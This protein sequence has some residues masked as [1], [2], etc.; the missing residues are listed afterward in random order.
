MSGHILFILVEGD[1]ED[2]VVKNFLKPYWERRFVKCEVFNFRGSGN[3]KGKYVE[4]T[5][6]ILSQP[7]HAALMLI[8]IKNDPFGIQA[9]S[10]THKEAYEKLRERLYAGLGMRESAALGIFP[11]VVE[12]E[13]WLLA[14]PDFQKDRL[15]KTFLHPENE[16]NP[17]DIIKKH[18]TS[19]R[20]GQFA[21]KHFDSA[22]AVK[23]YEDNC[24]HFVLLADW[25]TQEQPP[26]DN[27]TVRVSAET[28]QKTSD[29]QAEYERLTKQIE[30]NL[31]RGQTGAAGVLK[32]DRK[33]I[34]QQI[35]ELWIDSLHTNDIGD[36]E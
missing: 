28:K 2:A 13:T 14:D 25:I 15:K 23:V 18:I 1:T 8:D 27:R 6:R 31:M 21:K 33:Y 12:L 30:Q 22:S 36:D 20:K 19:Y 4:T 24:P 9:S 29:L 11:V 32:T 26:Q 35:N 7:N 5:R 34:E 16:P 10:A 17:S 3:L